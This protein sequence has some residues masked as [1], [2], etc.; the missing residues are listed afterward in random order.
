MKKLLLLI[1]S[2]CLLSLWLTS[3]DQEKTTYIE[4][5]SSSMFTNI[6]CESGIC[7]TTFVWH[8]G[9]IVFSAYDD[10]KTIN[11]SILSSRKKKKLKG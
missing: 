1:T 5:K 6:L 2:A 3:C 8:E 9:E 7:I 11:D 10:I 4:Q